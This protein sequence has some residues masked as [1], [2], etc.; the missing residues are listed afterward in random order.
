LSIDRSDSFFFLSLCSV[1]KGY[2]FCGKWRPPF[3]GLPTASVQL[4]RAISLL[5][6]TA[7][8]QSPDFKATIFIPMTF[9]GNLRAT[10]DPA[11]YE[12]DP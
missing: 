3:L 7:R 6:R 8:L 4:N 2:F 5:K 11:V 10:P 12:I 1:S 9:E